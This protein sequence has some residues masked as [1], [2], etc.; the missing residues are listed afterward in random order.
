MI[1]TV[2]VALGERVSDV[3]ASQRLTDSASCLGRAAAV[4]TVSLSVRWR[5]TT[6]APAASRSLSSTCAT[7]WCRHWQRP[8]LT[9]E[10]GP[11]SRR[12]CW[13]RRNPRRRGAG[14]SGGLRQAAEP[15]GGARR[16]KGGLTPPQ[17]LRFDAQQLRGGVAQHRRFLRRRSR[18]AWRGCDPPAPCSM[19]R[20]V[21][22]HEDLRH[23]D[24]GDQMPHRLGREHD[25]SRNELPQ[26]PVG[27][28]ERAPVQRSGKFS[29]TTSDRGA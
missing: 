8:R 12:S 22:S 20:I 13:S 17:R 5:G 28:L 6:V 3:R 15:A 23:A 24:L 14:G 27:F 26:I 25:R 19:E 2:K 21:R 18:R 1:A 10:E 11:T 4:P 16:G 29:Q 9:R 7:R